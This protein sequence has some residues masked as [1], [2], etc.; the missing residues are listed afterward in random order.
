MSSAEQKRVRER[1]DYYYR[2]ARAIILSRQNPNTGLI[3]ASVAVTTHG[4]YR[5][6]WVR[7]NVYSI[8]CVFGLALAYRRIDD[9]LGRAYE[10][11][12][13]TTKLMRGLLFSMMRQSAKV[14]RFKYTLSITDSLH[15]KYNTNTGDTVVGDSEWGHLQVDATSLFL[16]MLAQMTAAGFQVIYTLDEV[17][18]VQNLVFYIERAYR[19]PDY[20]IWER[21]N[22]VNHGEPELNSS[23]IGI[24]VAALQAINGVNLFGSR[25]GPSSVIH[26]LP[27]EVTRNSMILHSALPRESFSKEIDAALLAVIGYPAYAVADE[28]VVQKTRNEIV[29]KLRGRYGCKRFLRDG[30]QA[31]LEDNSRL[32]YDPQELRIFE[33][34]ECEWPLFFT[35]FILDGLFRGDTAAVEEYREAIKPLL[36]DSTTLSDY[37]D[38]PSVTPPMRTKTPPRTSPKSPGLTRE[39]FHLIPEVYYVPRE[40]VEAEK[41]N[42]HSQDRLPNDNVPLVW[43]NSLYMLGN[44]VHENLVS[45]AELDPLGRRFYARRADNRDTVVQIAL[46]AEDESLQAKLSTFGLDTQSLDQLG[47]VTICPP[48]ALA[49]VYTTLGMND[50]LGM[51]GRPPRPVGTL[52]TCRLYRVQGRLYAFVPHFLDKQEFYLSS[53]NDYLVSVIESQLSFVQRHWTFAGRPTLVI[54]LTHQMFNQSYPDSL[55]APPTTQSAPQSDRHFTSSQRHLLH[56]IMNLRSGLC[57]NGTV[58]VRLGNLN[59]LVPTSSVE[60]LDFLVNKNDVDWLGILRGCPT[61]SR[62][63]STSRLRELGAATP[64]ATPGG[65]APRRNTSFYNVNSGLKTPVQ[66]KEGDGYFPLASELRKRFNFKLLDPEMPDQSAG[67]GPHHYHSS[68]GA[69]SA[70]TTPLDDD[71]SALGLEPHPSASAGTA[72][73]VPLGGPGSDVG[74]AVMSPGLDS[75]SLTLNDPAEVPQAIAMLGSANNLFDQMDLLHYLFSCHGLKFYVEAMDA[76]VHELV[77]EVYMKAQY[78]KQWGVLRQA[79]GVLGKV[80]NNQLTICITD[81]VIRLKSLTIGHGSNEVVISS[82][83]PPDAINDILLRCCSEDLREIPLVQEVIINLADLIQAKPDMFDGLMRLRTHY[84]LIALREEISR[85]NNCDEEEALDILLEMSPFELKVLVNTIMSGPSLSKANVHSLVHSETKALANEGK[86]RGWRNVSVNAVLGDR[87]TDLFAADKTEL[88]ISVQ[89]AGFSAG[90]FARIDVNRTGLPAANRGINVVVLDPVEKSVAETVSF[91]TH[92]SE[93]DAQEFAD[94]VNGLEPHMVFIMA[95]KDD[96]AE[97]LTPEARQAVEALGSHMIGQ[98]GY[99]DSWC[100][101]GYKGA[102]REH[103]VEVRQAAARGPTDV[104]HIRYN[105]EDLRRRAAQTV[106]AEHDGPAATRPTPSSSGGRWL[107]RRKNDGALNRVPSDFYPRVWKVLEQCHGVVVQ[108][109]CLP[110]DPLIYEKTPEEPNFAIRVESFLDVIQDPAERQIAVECLMT[111]SLLQVTY[112]DSRP[113]RPDGEESVNVTRIFKDALGIFWDVWKQ[114]TGAAADLPFDEPLARRLFY[115]LP[116]AGEEHGTVY[117]LALS[118]LAHLG[119]EKAQAY[120]LECIGHYDTWE[121]ERFKVCTA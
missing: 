59:E 5:D 18:F 34:I 56:F 46:L 86:V 118:A 108:N 105:L 58:R 37:A 60:S 3:P 62:T 112:P 9:E 65:R 8:M 113:G 21:G 19:T 33:N 27:D 82:P 81:L 110:R 6:A 15:A 111:I 35:Y 103:I 88:S 99:R 68:M 97:R 121:K 120:A 116:T 104:L 44:L 47:S 87:P 109:E 95:V 22:K 52:S 51:S 23:S 45:T 64:L 31:V 24:V 115:D 54:L 78:L 93:A 106:G 41:A 98:L 50:K 57:C 4:D 94:F 49:E 85:L 89:S 48:T 67:E 39:T 1:L 2:A 28:E 10:L 13:S 96:A 72:L 84:I 63:G 74:P 43:A 11:E 16:L 114:Q 83:V 61:I 75:L 70:T 66:R 53:D 29:T 117:Y 7:D 107:R 100:F 40:S 20:G 17:D 101:V 91:D 30:H 32:Y 102:P 38:L 119:R 77:E 42:P 71:L 90:N 36:V 55:A 80:V 14:E 76:T 73:P 25:G 26:V 92:L 12:H 79:A 69:S